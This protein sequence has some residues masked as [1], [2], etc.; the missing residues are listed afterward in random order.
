MYVPGSFVQNDRQ[1]I[2]RLLLDNAFGIL[3]T[4]DGMATPQAS[5]LPML[6]EFDTD[7]ALCR[8]HCH[9]ARANPQARALADGA[10]ALAIFCGPHAYVSPRH[11]EAEFA[12]PTWNYAVIHVSGCVTLVTNPDQVRALLD[13]L[14][15][16]YE[17]EPPLGW[18]ADWQD[19]RADP[20]LE[21]I[22]AFTID[23]RQVQAKFKLNQNRS[24][25]DQLAVA[26][27]LAASDREAEQ[28]T[29]RLMLQQ[30]GDHRGAAPS[31]SPS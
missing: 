17:P 12:V 26:T 28:Q 20:L 5:H 23:V 24:A 9:L 18:Q 10:A 2:R 6:P 7:G 8:L 15:S 25:A 29:A 16:A 21:A 19:E 22:V 31:G 14:V 1:S 3:V 27:A 4:P 30:L 13:D 11:Y